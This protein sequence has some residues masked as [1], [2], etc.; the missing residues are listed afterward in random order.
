MKTVTPRTCICRWLPCEEDVVLFKKSPA[1]KLFFSFFD[2][3]FCKITTL[4][5]QNRSVGRGWAIT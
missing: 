2:Y 4:R 1:S 3:F 5:V